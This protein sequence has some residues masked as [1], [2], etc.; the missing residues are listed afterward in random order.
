[1]RGSG[2]IL[3]VPRAEKEVAGI[4]VFWMLPAP[5]SSGSAREGGEGG[6]QDGRV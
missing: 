1:M 6:L 5:P 3:G 4:G 2:G